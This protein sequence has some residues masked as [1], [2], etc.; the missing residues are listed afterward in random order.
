MAY[1]EVNGVRLHICQQGRGPVALFVHGF[2]LDA[3]MW[4]EQIDALSDLRRCISLDLRGF[5]RSSPVTGAPL[6]MDQHADDLAGVLDLVSEEEADVIGLSMGGYVALAFAE[7]HPD[8]LRSL[9]LLD[10]KPGADSEEAKAGRDAMAERL[11]EDGRVAV[12]EAMQTGLLGPDASVAAQARLRTMVE[13]CRYETIVG[14]LSGMRDRPD[15]TAV[16]SSVT[17]PAAV[18]VGE[19]DTVTPPA[20]A[21]FMANELPD[22]VLTVIAGAGHMTPI[23]QP[24]ATSAALRNHIERT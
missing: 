21:Q 8:R 13:A 10:T 5:G 23:E 1:A 9:A 4:I 3:S 19:Q 22:A 2:P 18:I 11:V 17:V 6:T 7:R 12:A 24:A 14:A 16:L 20:E 15:R